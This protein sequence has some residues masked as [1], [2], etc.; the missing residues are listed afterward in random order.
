MNYLHGGI[1]IIQRSISTS[2]WCLAQKKKGRIDPLVLKIRLER[3]V[4]R[5]ESGI[6]RIEKA[7]KQ[8]I[9]IYEQSLQPTVQ[10]E[11]DIRE[12]DETDPQ[13]DARYKKML[14]VWALYK[15][16]EAKQEM[17]CLR[18]VTRAQRVALDSLRQ[19]S[20]SLWSEAVK[21]DPQI[22]PYENDYIVKETPAN[23]DYFPPDGHRKDITKHWKL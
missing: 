1:N 6:E 15:F 3:K 5:L 4:K 14:K 19:L 16:I 12:R 9:P 23:P 17:K 21:P 20:P 18:S 22:L 11:I 8:L 13:F 2:A 10:K 7:P